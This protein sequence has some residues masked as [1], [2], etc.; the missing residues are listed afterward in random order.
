ME[1]EIPSKIKIVDIKGKGRGVVATQK[2]EK[3]EVI[4]T[5]PLSCY[6]KK[7]AILL[8]KRAIMPF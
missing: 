3:G 5:A 1:I 6:L 8:K 2:I 4:E 7:S